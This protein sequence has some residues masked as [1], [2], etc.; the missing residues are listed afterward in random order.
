MIL[1]NNNI[2]Y[3]SVV[4][5]WY[6]KRLPRERRPLTGGQ[7]SCPQWWPPWR[8]WSRWCCCRGIWR[9]NPS[10]RTQWSTRKCVWNLKPVRRSLAWYRRETWHWPAQ[11][12][13]VSGLCVMY[14]QPWRLV[15]LQKAWRMKNVMREVWDLLPVPCC[16]SA[17]WLSH[18]E[19][20][21]SLSVNMSTRL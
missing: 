6:C 1:I 13:S 15:W 12:P 14:C 9:H 3:L 18:R 21:F 17:Y 10:P 2:C 5:G 20:S 7:S 11:K 4:P 19:T 16:T 8:S